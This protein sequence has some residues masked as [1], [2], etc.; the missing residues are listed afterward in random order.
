M[1]SCLCGIAFTLRSYPRLSQRERG[2]IIKRESVDA[3]E[4]KEQGRRVG[5]RGERDSSSERVGGQ[6]SG[7]SYPT[8]FPCPARPLRWSRRASQAEITAIVERRK[9]TTN[10]RPEPCCAAKKRAPT[11]ESRTV[12]S[13]LSRR[14]VT[15]FSK[16]THRV[17]QDVQKTADVN[18]YTSGH[19]Q[20]VT[21]SW[22]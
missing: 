20:G 15:Q 10:C 11:T 19:G 2:T 8:T 3:I 13:S 16:D 7:R 1:R 9:G 6:T 12:H 14:L 18:G 22:P 17:A 5:I 4:W 21:Y